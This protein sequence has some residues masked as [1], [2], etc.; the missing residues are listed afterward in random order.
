MRWRSPLFV[1]GDRPDLADKAQRYSPD[2]VILDL[3]DAVPADGKPAA[4]S[5]VADAAAR[6]PEDLDIWIRVNAPG[7]EWFADD[8]AS[9][10]PGIAGIVVPKWEAPLGL[11]LP[12]IA[13]L[14]GAVGVAD[15]RTILQGSVVGCYFG[16]EDYIADLGGVRTPTNAEVLFARSAVVLAARVA[17]IHALD[18]VTLDFSDEGRF[19]TE[20]SE[21]RAL[22]YAGKLC[23]HPKQVALANEAFAPS[24]EEVDRARRLLA[25]FERNGGHV[26]TFEGQM[27]DEVIAAQARAVLLSP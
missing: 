18:M 23:I 16:A 11:T 27:V 9:L 15:A 17:G 26:F 24:P 12:V 20:A 21:A 4:R 10:P 5:N 19:R 1:P 25:A 6:L 14:E 8:L 7:T 3:E 13:G 2:A 22:G